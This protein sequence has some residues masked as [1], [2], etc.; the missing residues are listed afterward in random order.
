MLCTYMNWHAMFCAPLAAVTGFFTIFIGMTDILL[1]SLLLVSLLGL[2]YLYFKA[3]R[4]NQV[5]AGE[6]PVQYR[7]ILTSKV[8]FYQKL[9][10][11]GRQVFENRVQHFLASIKITG[12]GTNVEDIDRV[13]IAAGAIIPIFGFPNWEYMNLNEVLL[14]PDAFDHEFRQ[15]GGE[16]HILGMVGSGAY[17]N[18]MLLSQHE[19]REGFSNKSDKG[20]TAIHEFVHL[21][22]KTDGAVDG[23]PE[24]LLEQQYTLPWINRIHETIKQIVENRSDINPYGATNEAEFFAVVAEYFF[25]RPDLLESKHPEL[26]QL[27]SGMFRQDPAEDT[28]AAAS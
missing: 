11:S 16:R 19:L 26:Y 6:M 15:Q 21:I 3:K 27:L 18:V 12:V 20:N 24:F 8:V 7:D 1:I 5:P 25:E 22:D 14:Y 10:A 13:L 28:G 17:Q 2:P 4:K 23:V 9:D